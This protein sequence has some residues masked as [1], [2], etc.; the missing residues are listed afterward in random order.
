MSCDNDDIIS[1]LDPERRSYLLHS[2]GG[3]QTIITS[4]EDIGISEG[5]N[6]IN[7]EGG[8]YVPAHR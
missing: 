7:V 6:L 1:E 4:C 2:I 3:M 5:A 8:S